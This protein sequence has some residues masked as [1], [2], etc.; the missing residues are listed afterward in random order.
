MMA[1]RILG[2]VAVTALLVACAVGRRA[3]RRDAGLR[4]AIGALLFSSV[5]GL[6]TSFVRN[7]LVVWP[8]GLS[9]LGAMIFLVWTMHAETKRKGDL[10]SPA[11]D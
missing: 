10:T 1:P 8:L 9:M 11:S 6:T 3:L 7:P 5:A 4:K 2:F